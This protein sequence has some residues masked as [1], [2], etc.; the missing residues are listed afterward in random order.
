MNDILLCLILFCDIDACV[1]V[2]V[3]RRLESKLGSNDES[4]TKLRMF[5]HAALSY[6]LWGTVI[7]YLRRGGG[8]ALWK[9]CDPASQ[10]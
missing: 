6:Q 10:L 5:V 7:F 4:H 1:I 8:K 9:L 2:K 3:Y